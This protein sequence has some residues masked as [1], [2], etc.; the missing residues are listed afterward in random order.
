[1]TSDATRI[2]TAAEAPQ[3]QDSMQDLGGSPWPEFL[4]H[5]TVVNQNW[6]RLYEFHPECQLALLDPTDGSLLAIANSLP[7]RWDGPPEGLPERGVEWALESRFVA[8][9]P[10]APNVLCAL[11]I[12]VAPALLNHGLSS[13]MVSA[14]RRVAAE[15]GLAHLI[16]PVRPVWK[17]RYP[18]VPMERYVRWTRDDGLPYDPWMRVHVRLGASI[19][20]VCEASLCVEGTREQWEAWTAL[21]LPESGRYTLEGGLVPMDFDAAR[22]LGRYVEPNVWMQHA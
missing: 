20:Q 9:A 6:M 19:L 4:L 12:V 8:E 3:L 21:R 18:L 13:T 1:V 22:N 10:P 15:R 7:V 5:S 14:M 16:A 11:Q 17:H 2:V